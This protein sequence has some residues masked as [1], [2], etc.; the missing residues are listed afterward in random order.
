MNYKFYGASHDDVIGV[1]VSGLKKGF[2]IDETL[3]ATRLKER[4]AKYKFNTSRIEKDEVYF[5]DGVENNKIIKDIIIIE[6][7]NNN[8]KKKDY[9]Q[10]VIRPSHSDII[11]YLQEGEKYDY[12][13]GGKF[14]GRFT[15][16]YVVIGAII[17]TN[18]PKIKIYGQIKEVL[19]LK[20]DKIIL[21]TSKQLEELNSDFPVLNPIVKIKMKEVISEIANSGNSVGAKLTFKVDGVP[22]L[23]GGMYFNSFESILSK[24]LFGIGAIKGV[25][26]GLGSEYLN[27]LGSE[28]N[29]VYYMQENKIVSAKNLQGGINGGYTNGIESII[30]SVIVRPTPSIHLKQQTIKYENNKFIDYEYQLNGRHDAFIANRIISVV[31]AVIYMAIYEMGENEYKN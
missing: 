10:G 9:L 25:E 6:I 2:I 20:D 16:L 17:E 26:F 5:I 31:K 13:G 14:S 30:F 12:A 19:D 29:D 7:P 15:A 1:E 23:T 21:A 18:S 4:Q 27:C 11:G 28:A 8:I 24:Y 22:A 3:I